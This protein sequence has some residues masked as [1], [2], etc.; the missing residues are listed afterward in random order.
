MPRKVIYLFPTPKCGSNSRSD[1][2]NHKFGQMITYLTKW[3]KGAKEGVVVAGGQGQGT[4]L[5]QLSTP[6]G[7][8]VDQLGS[9]YVADYGNNRIMRWLK[10]AKEGNVVVVGNGQGSPTNQLNTPIGLS[11]DKANNLYVVDFGNQRVQQFLLD[12]ST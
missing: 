10:G 2:G 3:V 7:I 8:I 11:F 5:M 6:Y 1:S 4:S 12:S 9:V